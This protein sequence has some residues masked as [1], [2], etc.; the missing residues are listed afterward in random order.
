MNQWY[1][2]RGGQQHGPVGLDELRG[3]VG[4]GLLNPASDLVWNSSMPNWLP[5]GQVPELMGAQQGSPLASPAFGQPFA[6]PLASGP[7]VEISPGSEPLIPTACVKRAFDLT[8]RHLGPLIII[9]VC[10]SVISWGATFV[11]EEIDKA[12]GWDSPV[13][14]VN[15]A[16]VT[17]P[18]EGFKIGY[19]E[20]SLSVPMTIISQILSVFLWLGATKIGLNAVSGKPFSIGTLFS[21]G[22]W[23]VRGF[24]GYLLYMAM[25]VVGLVLLIVPGIYLALRFGMYQAAI[26]DR[27][28][29]VIDAFKYS[30]QLTQKNVL[31]L[32]VIALFTFLIILAGCMALL[33]GLL[34]AYP[35][36]WLMWMVAYRWLQYGGRAVM[37]DPATGRPLLAALSE[38]IP[39]ASPTDQPV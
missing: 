39:A 27:N 7:I 31:N 29:G 2:A 28:M 5:A 35:M 3:L 20:A 10:L 23:L 6:Y 30:A 12:L 9:V 21:G 25:I 13:Q 24:I 14:T 18:W 1:Y 15:P 37:D 8:L 17:D 26:V 19:A 11:F 34:F 22:K 36:I 32:F 16:P 38:E 33:V 4:N